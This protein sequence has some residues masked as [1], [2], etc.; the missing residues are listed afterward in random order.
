MACASLTPAHSPDVN[1]LSV[2]VA[3]GPYDTARV[4]GIPS[5]QAALDAGAARSAGLA[6]VYRDFEGPLFEPLA[7]GRQVAVEARSLMLGGV[8]RWATLT[9]C[10]AAVTTVVIQEIPLHDAP[11]DEADRHAVEQWDLAAMVACIDA[12]FR[13][14]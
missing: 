14:R 4:L 7:D 6:K 8:V 9:S 5:M 1:V 10:N 11:L 13:A 2:V 12:R 3:S